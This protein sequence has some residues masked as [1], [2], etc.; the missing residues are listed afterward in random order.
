MKFLGA[1]VLAI[2]LCPP[3]LAGDEPVLFGVAMWPGHRAALLQ[4]PD[5]DHPI[6]VQ[7]GDSVGTS[8]VTSIRPDAVTLQGYD[9]VTILELVQ[10]DAVARPSMPPPPSPMDLKAEI[11]AHSQG[12]DQHP[13]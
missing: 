1:L 6:L 13:E 7:E 5:A 12:N 9:G 2:S 4:A 10:D 3:A 11:Q 8:R